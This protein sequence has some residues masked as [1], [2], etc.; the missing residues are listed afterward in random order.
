M[1]RRERR[2]EARQLGQVP[3][4]AFTAAVKDVAAEGPV[5]PVLV[6]PFEGLD[7]T[8]GN[9]PLGGLIGHQVSLSAISRTISSPASCPCSMDFTP[10]AMQP[11][12]PGAVYTWV[13]RSDA[14]STTG[15]IPGYVNCSDS[16]G[17]YSEATPPPAVILIWLAPFISCSRVRRSTSGTPSASA[18]MPCQLA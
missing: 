14:A 2:H 16:S 7:R 11:R 10:A 12:M 6:G 13:P 17:S 1:Q 3:P 8:V 5:D 9:L 18:D 4:L 15:R